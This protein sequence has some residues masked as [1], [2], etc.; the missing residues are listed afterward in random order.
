MVIPVFEIVFF[1]FFN[2]QNGI[3]KERIVQFCSLLN[4][5]STSVPKLWSF[6]L[7]LVIRLVE[8][9]KNI[10]YMDEVGWVGVEWDG[11]VE[12]IYHLRFS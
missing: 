6:V 7:E 3:T 5:C 11:L 9:E 12:I 1:F 2:A 4:Y 10:Y 8:I